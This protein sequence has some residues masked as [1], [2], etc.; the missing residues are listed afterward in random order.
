MQSG[1]AR[2]GT[3]VP[4]VAIEESRGACE[5]NGQDA[6]FT[7]EASPGNDAKYVAVFPTQSA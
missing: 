4:R 1:K 6:R 3:G 2:G 7:T 5:G